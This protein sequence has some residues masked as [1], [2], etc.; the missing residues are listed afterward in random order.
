MP[1]KPYNGLGVVSCNHSCGQS[2]EKKLHW[3]HVNNVVV[4]AML[5]EGSYCLGRHQESCCL[6]RMGIWLVDL[7]ANQQLQ[8]FERT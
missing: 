3:K 2:R 5:L 4:E 8:D 6:L 7:E 1:V